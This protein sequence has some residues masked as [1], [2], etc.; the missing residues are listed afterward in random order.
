MPARFDRVHDALARAPFELLVLVPGP[1]YSYVSGAPN[2]PSERLNLLVIPRDGRPAALLPALEVG[3]FEGLDVALYPWR[4]GEGPQDAL[5]ALVR[6]LGLDKARLGIEYGQMRY[7]EAEMLRATAPGARLV[8]G[9]GLLTSLRATK[10]AS[11]L[12]AMR[13]AIEISERALDATIEVIRPGMSENELAAELRIQLLRAGSQGEAFDPIISSG[14]R[15]ANPHFG[16]SEKR[17]APGDVI[18]IDFGGMWEGYPADI[19]RCVAL[20][21]VPEEIATIYDL[22]RAA[23]EAGRAAVAPGVTIETVDAAARTVIERGGYGD[24]FIHRTGHGLGMEVHEPPYIV[25]GNG[26][27][28]AVGMTFTVEPGIYL[29]GLGGVRVEDNVVVTE[30]GAESLTSYSRDLIRIA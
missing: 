13:R 4:D 25:A 29:P 15:S 3:A 12:A 11:E 16:P 14:A 21:P 1:N 17:L 27:P 7:G 2:H 30:T 10:D 6:D 8:P 26:Q 24:R 18:I 22:C 9:D 19:T 5:R 23:N 20:E 28:L